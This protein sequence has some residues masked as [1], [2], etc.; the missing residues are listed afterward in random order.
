VG[1]AAAD[2]MLTVKAKKRIAKGDEICFDYIKI[3][4][5]PVGVKRD[6]LLSKYHFL[7]QCKVCQQYDEEQ[8]KAQE[9]EEQQSGRQQGSSSSKPKGKGKK[10]NNNKKKKKRK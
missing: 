8:R 5:L 10:S 3:A 4:G 7:C 1:S 9:K 2:A 6:L